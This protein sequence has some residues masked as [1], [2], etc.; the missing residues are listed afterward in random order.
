[1][2]TRQAEAKWRDLN[3]FDAEDEDE[4][5]SKVPVRFKGRCS[6]SPQETIRHPDRSYDWY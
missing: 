5:E 1:M 2:T 4:W 3:S 6:Q